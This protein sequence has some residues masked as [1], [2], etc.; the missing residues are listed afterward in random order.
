M[1][2]TRYECPHFRILVIGRANAGKTTILEKVCGVER[3]SKP[4]IYDRDDN[5]IDE[6]WQP[7]VSRWHRLL[8]RDRKP[9]PDPSSGHLAPSIYA[10]EIKYNT[11]FLIISL[12]REEYMISSIR[13]HTPAA[14]SS[15]MTQ[16]ALRLGE[17]TR[18]R[19]L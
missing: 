12:F 13:S 18:S 9:Q 10:S 14:T 7:P 1:L 16:K 8:G 15:F 17:R 11:P 6:D 2:K 3:G 5:E 4:V 19:K